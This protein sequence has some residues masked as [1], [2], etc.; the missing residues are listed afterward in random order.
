MSPN[1]VYMR[2]NCQ[3][4]SESFCDRKSLV[5]AFWIEHKILKE[6]VFVFNRINAYYAISWHEKVLLLFS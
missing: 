4:H 6:K 1:A 5:C 2:G 3:V